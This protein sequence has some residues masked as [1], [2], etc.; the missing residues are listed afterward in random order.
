MAVNK[1]QNGLPADDYGQIIQVPVKF[2]TTDGANAS[3]LTVADTEIDLA[4]PTNAVAFVAKAKAA[5]CRIAIKDNTGTNYFILYDGDSDKFPCSGMTHISVLR[6][7]AASVTLSY[8]FE[9]IGD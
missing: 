6:N 9:L 2:V 8:R 1:R 5:D 7:A 3:P 4:V